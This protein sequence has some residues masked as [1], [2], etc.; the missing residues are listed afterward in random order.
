MVRGRGASVHGDL[1]TAAHEAGVTILAGTDTRPHG[2]VVGEIR[3]LA[4]TE[5]LAEAGFVIERLREVTEPD[6][7]DKRY[8]IPLFLHVCASRR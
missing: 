7:S 3:A 6:P 1:V 4:S 8:R 2:R 5:A